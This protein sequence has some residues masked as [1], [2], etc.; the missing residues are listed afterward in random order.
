M[1]IW[2]LS[3]LY[4]VLY[5]QDVYLKPDEILVAYL[6]G[7][8]LGLFLLIFEMKRSHVKPYTISE[9]CPLVG[10]LCVWEN[11]HAVTNTNIEFGAVQYSDSQSGSM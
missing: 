3:T 10:F 1:Y 7:L 8:Y 9:H 4:L 11:T 6:A 2:V 5:G